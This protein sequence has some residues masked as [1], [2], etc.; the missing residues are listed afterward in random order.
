MNM[1]Q[2]R[3]D[4]GCSVI[5]C[6][7]VVQGPPMTELIGYVKTLTSFPHP[8]SIEM[9]FREATGK[10]QCKVCKTDDSLEPDFSGWSALQIMTTLMSELIT[11]PSWF[12]SISCF[13]SAGHGSN[14]MIITS[15]I[16]H[17]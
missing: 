2:W 6:D 14:V 13:G 12:T 8:S 5:T 7:I 11:I 17:Q 3:A 9:P 16:S 1:S 15:I 10:Q 4:I